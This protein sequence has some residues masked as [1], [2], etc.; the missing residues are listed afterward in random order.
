M[1]KARRRK[2]REKPERELPMLQDDRTCWLC[3][4]SAWFIISIKLH[5]QLHSDEPRTRSIALV[6]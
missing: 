2:K 4:N 3:A 5:P 6:S 1:R